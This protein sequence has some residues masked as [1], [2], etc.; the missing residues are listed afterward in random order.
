MTS[1][2]NQI[3]PNPQALSIPHPSLSVILQT[4][5]PFLSPTKRW[6]SVFRKT[7]RENVFWVQYCVFLLQN[8]SYPSSTSEQLNEKRNWFVLYGINYTLD[9]M[10]NLK[11]PF[12]KALYIWM[13]RWRWFFGDGF[14]LKYIYV[15]SA[16]ILR[17]VLKKREFLKILRDDLKKVLWVVL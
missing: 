14:L 12:W 9:T 4:P 6:Q 13:K 7:I 5:S 2:K 8:I 16:N 17:G 1:P 15:Y 3:F 10:S 11:I